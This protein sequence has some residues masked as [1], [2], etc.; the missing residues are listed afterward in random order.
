MPKYAKD[1]NS[2][3]NDPVENVQYRRLITKAGNCLQLFYN[4]DNNLLVVDLIA[5]SEKGGNEIVRMTL[6]EDRLLKGVS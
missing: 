2:Y 6:D 5:K 1:S 3:P 4:P